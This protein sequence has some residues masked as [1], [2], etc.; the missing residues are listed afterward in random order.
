M[1]TLLKDS[2]INNVKGG[3]NSVA[4]GVYQAPSRLLL[5]A[6]PLTSK[7][8]LGFGRSVNLV[9]LLRIG[10]FGSFGTY[11]GGYAPV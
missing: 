11:R 1:I 2:E 7:R 8:P 9:T 5:A 10:D 4:G 3:V 6:N